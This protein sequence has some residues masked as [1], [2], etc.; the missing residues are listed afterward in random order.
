M[1]G[2]SFFYDPKLLGNS[3]FKEDGYYFCYCKQGELSF[4]FLNSLFTFSAGDA[5]I[6]GNYQQNFSVVSVSDGIDFIGVFVTRARL[7]SMDVGKY[8]TDAG[9]KV[10][11]FFH[12]VV[13]MSEERSQAVLQSFEYL[14]SRM[15]TKMSYHYEDAVGLAFSRLILDLSEGQMERYI[16][17]DEPDASEKMFKRFLQLVEEGNYKLHR[18]VAWY[19]GQLCITPKHLSHCVKT[20][21]G[22]NVKYWIDGACIHSL[23]EDLKTK[24]ATQICKEYGF[25]SLSY[26]SRYVKRLIGVSPRFVK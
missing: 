10:S 5:L 8:A 24:P 19:A 15:E 20:V 1:D 11:L 21:S 13:Q 26:L 22:Q 14:R 7:A 23:V 6:I 2:L 25:S 18:D 12:P 4:T 16:A 17:Q 3:F 9:R